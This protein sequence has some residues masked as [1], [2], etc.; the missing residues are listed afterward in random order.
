VLG[1]GSSHIGDRFQLRQAF[2]DDLGRLQGPLGQ[3]RVFDNLALDPSGLT[4]RVAQGLQ[5]RDELVAPAPSIAA[6]F[7]TSSLSVL[8]PLTSAPAM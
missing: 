4:L 7:C 2:G 8:S 5:L 6:A 1:F 3:G